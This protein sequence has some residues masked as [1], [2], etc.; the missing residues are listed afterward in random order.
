MKRDMIEARGV[1]MAR[2][3]ALVEAVERVLQSGYPADAIL[4]HYFR[5][6]E[7]LGVQDRAFVAETLYA[8][9]RRIEWL[10]TLAPLTAPRRLALATLLLVQGR[11]LRDVQLLCRGEESAWL[12]GLRSGPG[13]EGLVQQADLPSW[14]VEQ[15]RPVM[16]DTDILALG[17]ALQRAAPLDLR[18]NGWLAQRPS[19]LQMLAEAGVVAEATPWSPWGIRIQGR[20]ALQG[21]PLFTSGQVEVQDEGSQLLGLLL[22]PQRRHMVVD[23]CA[24]AGGKTLQLGALMH[25]QGRVYAF[26]ISQRR[27][28]HLKPRLKR[29]GL[30]NITPVLIAHENDPRVKR[31]A[32]KIDRVLVDAPCSGMGTL[33]RNPDLKLR[34]APQDIATLIQKQRSILAAAATLVKP[35]GH[36]VYATCSLLPQE[37]DAQA[38]Y[39]QETH[40]EFEVLSCAELLSAQQVPDLPGERL[41]LLPQVHGTDG[42]FAAAWRR[43]IKDPGPLRQKSGT[44]NVCEPVLPA[45]TGLPQASRPEMTLMA[46]EILPEDDLHEDRH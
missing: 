27:L 43:K 7:R 39:F 31:L 37:N 12:E 20:P 32:G 8:L 44:A 11:A 30:S 4:H 34:Q 18:V 19:V 6:R 16:S 25:N 21:M 17:R 2:F 23:F 40:P 38:D 28:N 41:H 15:L 26:D 24:G 10:R 3:E 35:G 45:T 42:F 33:R 29:S 1:P 9:L 14:V 5:E 36:L 13:P 46:Q 22:A